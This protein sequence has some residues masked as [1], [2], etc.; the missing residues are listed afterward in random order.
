M[1]IVFMGTPNF[2]VPSLRR[3]IADGHEVAA[4][5]TQ[6]DKPKNR[7]MKL[8]PTPVK[9]VATEANIP[10]FQPQS[11]RDEAVLEEIRQMKPELLVVAAYGKI[12]P[13]ALLQI[14]TVAAINVHSS[15][16]P[17]YRGAAPINWA[18]LNGDEETG[19]TIQHLVVE[20]DA[21]DIITVRKTPIDPQED[22]AQ[23]YDRDGLLATA[24]A[25]N[26]QRSFGAD[27]ISRIGRSM[28]GDGP[29]LADCVRQA[30]A[31]LL[32]T[33]CG[34]AGRRS[35]EI[36]ALVLTGNTAMLH[37]LCGLDVSPLAAAPFQAEE[38]FG[39]TLPAAELD[40]PCA[41]GARAYLPRCMS[42]FVGADI[43]TAL[44]A[45]GICAGRETRMLTDIG[46]NGEIALWHQGRLSCCSTAAGPAFEGANLSQGMQGAPGAIDHAWVADGALEVHTIGEAEPAGICGSGVADVLAGLLELGRLDETGLLNEGDDAWPLA[47]GVAITQGDIRQVQLAKSAVRAGIETLM[48]RAGLAPDALAEL[49]IAG[50]FGSYLSLDSAAA[51]GLIPPELK[52]RCRVLG[53]A[54]LAGA[55]MLLRSRPL[56][57]ESAAL[58][59]AAVTAELATDPIFME[60]YVEQMMF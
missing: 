18:I 42:A 52:P 32:R 24:A 34:Q 11:V 50:G 58:A 30:I 3:L 5:F 46:T 59:K 22:A 26:P 45:S 1:R 13:E 43:T 35:E 44:L 8:I 55:A 4:V 10:V 33:L 54:A 7:G 31:S 48:A 51:I 53:N 41:P 27:V 12:L 6:P 15:L 49:A 17:K 57:D 28:E 14:P 47:P 21:G 60:Q 56:V 19:V 23:L 38:L 25:P 9:E 2:A 29:A 40:L 36:D 39:K 16:L 20:L 37:L